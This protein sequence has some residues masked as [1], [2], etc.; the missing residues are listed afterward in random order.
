M[1]AI[2]VKNGIAGG[3]AATIFQAINSPEF[4]ATIVVGIIVTVI[5]TTLSYVLRNQ[6]LPNIF[7]KKDK[8]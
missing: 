2:D 5:T 8:K 6:V 1:V 7:K 4:I 3:V